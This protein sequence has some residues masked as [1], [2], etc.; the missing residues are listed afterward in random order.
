MTNIFGYDR[1][2]LSEPVY[3]PTLTHKK[4]GLDPSDYRLKGVSHLR[5]IELRGEDEPGKP[6]W[7]H[8]PFNTWL[9]SEQGAVITL[10][11]GSEMTIGDGFINLRIPTSSF[12]AAQ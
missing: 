12:S 9:T 7:H 4:G 6:T 5:E 10:P 2:P 11:E 3:D 8:G 1:K